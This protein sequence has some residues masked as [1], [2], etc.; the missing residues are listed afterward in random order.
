MATW[1]ILAALIGDG[2]EPPKPDPRLLAQRIDER[3]DASL[4]AAQ[5]VASDAADDAELLRRLSLDLIGRIPTVDE[6]RAFLADSD[7]EKRSRLIDRLSRSPEQAKHFARVW[8]GLLLPEAESEPQ[9]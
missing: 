1:L 3:I 4:A 5:A 6:V 9:V 2:G 8:R 7:P